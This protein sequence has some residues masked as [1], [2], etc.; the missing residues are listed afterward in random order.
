[1]PAESLLVLGGRRAAAARAALV[2]CVAALQRRASAELARRLR[3]SHY[4]L[5]LANQVRSGYRDTIHK[6]ARPTVARYYQRFE[7]VAIL[8]GTLM[9]LAPPATTDFVFVKPQTGNVII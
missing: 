3:A 8:H 6:H 7:R 4:Y 2:R 5:H 1:M 9:A